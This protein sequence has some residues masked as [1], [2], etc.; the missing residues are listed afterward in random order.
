MNGAKCFNFSQ[1]IIVFVSSILSLEEQID[2]G[3]YIIRVKTFLK[4]AS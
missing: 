4:I 1:E 2:L 3:K